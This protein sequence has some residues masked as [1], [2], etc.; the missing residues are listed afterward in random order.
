LVQVANHLR[1]VDSHAYPSVLP[2]SPTWCISSCITS[3][4]SAER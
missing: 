2:R 4:S 1:R 3:F